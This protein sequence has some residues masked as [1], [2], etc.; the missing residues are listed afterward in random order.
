MLTR[1]SVGSLSLVCDCSNR[2]K[3][4]VAILMSLRQGEISQ[5]GVWRWI[6]WKARSHDKGSSGAATRAMSL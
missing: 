2:S 1:V 3:V 5:R 4:G 6:V